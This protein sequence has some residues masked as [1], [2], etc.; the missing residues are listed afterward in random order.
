[1]GRLRVFPPRPRSKEYFQAATGHF[2]FLGRI[3]KNTSWEKETQM[4]LT[5]CSVNFKY[6]AGC[7]G[8]DGS[9]WM[10]G[11]TIISLVDSNMNVKNYIIPENT[12][13]ACTMG[14]DGNLWAVGSTPL[15][16]TLDYGHA[17][18]TW[19]KPDGSFG[20][21]SNPKT[22]RFYSVTL[23]KDGNIWTCGIGKGNPSYG[24]IACLSAQGEYLRIIKTFDIYR[25]ILC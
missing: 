6:A 11:S 7:L 5:T 14:S 20:T 24:L 13:N 25:N 4:A 10:V 12:F 21:Y 16:T 2:G 1:M 8:N 9:V 23:G 22:S 17:C 15:P 19:G 3:S 18:V